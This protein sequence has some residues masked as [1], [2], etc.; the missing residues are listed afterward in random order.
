MF[1]SEADKRWKRVPQGEGQTVTVLYYATRH[2]EIVNIYNRF[3]CQSTEKL[4]HEPAGNQWSDVTIDIQVWKANSYLSNRCKNTV[5]EQI[6]QILGLHVPGKSLV[7]CDMNF[8]AAAAAIQPGRSRNGGD[9]WEKTSSGFS[10]CSRRSAIP[11]GFWGFATT[12]TNRQQG[13]WDDQC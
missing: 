7:D 2:R 12:H 13:V 6:F 3:V 10:F 11:E 8:S 1:I 4:I 5:V 9:C